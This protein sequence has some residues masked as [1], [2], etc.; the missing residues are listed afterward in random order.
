MSVETKH[1]KDRRMLHFASIEESLRDAEM[2]VA[3]EREGRLVA[4]GNWTLGQAL[5]HVAGW[6]GYALDGYPSDLRPAWYM[7]I[8]AKLFKR[9]LMRGLPAGMRLP[10][11]EGGTKSIESLSAQ[12]GLAR[13]K[14]AWE[15][16]G[17][18]APTIENPLLGPLGHDEWIA[19]NLRH[20]E[21]HQGFFKA[22]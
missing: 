10:G 15:R 9:R 13:L 3:A 19:M 6:I 5:G 2:L 14:G 18:T 16:L 8:V 20:A 17:K 22:V 7:K 1:V 12:E 4:M 11:V 21:L